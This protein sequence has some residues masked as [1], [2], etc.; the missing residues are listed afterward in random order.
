MGRSGRGTG[1]VRLRGARDRD[2]DRAAT[3]RAVAACERLCDMDALSD[4]D[5]YLRRDTQ[6]L[7]TRQHARLL[8]VAVRTW[9]NK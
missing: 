8:L 7:T 2:R 4:D 3:E 1:Q 9:S 6:V 5:D